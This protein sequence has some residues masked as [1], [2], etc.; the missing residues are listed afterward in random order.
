[1]KRE[2][3]VTLAK[4]A[5]VNGL[6]VGKALRMAETLFKKF[7]VEGDP[8]SLRDQIVDGA[9]VKRTKRK[10]ETSNEDVHRIADLLE[11]ETDETQSPLFD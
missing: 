6:P 11:G 1:M 4:K 7:K 9:K 8:G 2:D 5:I 10:E 3:I